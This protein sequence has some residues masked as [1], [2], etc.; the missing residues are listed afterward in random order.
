MPLSFIT[1][2]GGSI[3]AIKAEKSSVYRKFTKIYKEI[4]GS[5]NIY[6]QHELG[7]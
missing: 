1:E 7:F 6:V 5:N 3:Y 2:G 4:Y